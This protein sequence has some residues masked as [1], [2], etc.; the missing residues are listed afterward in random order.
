MITAEVLVL[1]GVSS[2]FTFEI[3]S[4]LAS[5]AV[6]G[7]KVIAPFGKSKV[8]GIIMTLG[9]A[10][11]SGVIKPIESVSSD[12]PFHSTQL[13]LINWITS[14]YQTTPFI[15][16]QTVI[17]TKKLR[18]KDCVDPP[19]KKDFM[20]PYTLTPQ[21]QEALD[22]LLTLQCPHTALIHG[23]TGSGKTE[24]YIQIAHHMVSQGKQVIILVPEIALTPQ[25]RKQFKTRFGE[26]IAVLHSGMTA[27]SR[28]IEWTK[29]RLGHADIVIGP[30]SAIFSPMA[31][32]GAI[33]IDEEHDSSYK[34]DSSPRYSTHTIA[35]YLAESHKALLILGSATPSV[36]SY[37]HAINHLHWTLIT[38]TT[39]PNDAR[40]PPITCTDEIASL[41]Q[42]LLH[43][44][45]DRLDK[46]EKTVLLLNR[47]GFST[48]INCTKCHHVLACR[49]CKLNLT[50]HKDR[51]LR[52]H[53]CS[54]VYTLTHTCPKCKKQSLNFSG[55]AIQKVEVDL[56]KLLP[57]AT[58]IRM[59]K[60]TAP[61]EKKATAILDQF[62]QDGDILIGTQM[63]AKGHHIEEVTLV[64]IIGIDS[65]L[66]L[67]D[68]RSP[69]RTFQLIT[70][71]AGRA[72]RG[73][74]RGEV[75]IQTQHESH[76]AITSAKTHDYPTFYKHEI[77]YR[78]HL[79]Y[80]PFS[81]LVNII[82][83]GEDLFAVQKQSQLLHEYLA[84]EFKGKDIQMTPPSPCAID[85]V[86]DQNR[87]H[88][89]I[90]SPHEHYDHIKAALLHRPSPLKGVRVLVDFDPQSLF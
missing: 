44:I 59:D 53:R 89:L 11:P 70:Q 42:A 79:Y 41:S 87:W 72:G 78:E 63:V 35:H 88:L 90:K 49:E 71:V 47:R 22:Q 12:I 85:K 43:A 61:N 37:Y 55:N 50:Y 7:A 64:G 20:T 84:T 15:A 19:V 57:N 13:E 80:P 4:H 10:T 69:E 1:R 83:S 32:I 75:L 58:I 54:L 8:E 30:R 9:M 73:Q 66:N 68:F 52:C 34:Q 21:Q 48:Y 40:L 56:K 39:R 16:F 62:K 2:F 45:Q 33:I 31:N 6:I 38:L 36:E 17:G 46:T 18:L 82:M 27:K 5:A 23:I 86:R 3:P 81:I 24:L 14:Y 29:M 76:Y 65:T 28:D 77:T 74:K 25:F 60:D 67:P 26:R 51:T